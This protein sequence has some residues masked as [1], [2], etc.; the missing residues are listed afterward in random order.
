MK[1]IKYIEGVFKSRWLSKFINQ[2]SFTS[3]KIKIENLIYS[4][5]FLYK[6]NYNFCGLSY[7][8]QALEKIKPIVGLK[9]Y[10]KSWGRKKKIRVASFILPVGLQY[11]KA[12]FWL[13]KSMKLRKEIHLKDKL[14][15]ELNDILCN[16]TSLALKK[17]KEHYKF[18]VMFKAVKKFKW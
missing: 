14:V 8:F 1:Q 5:L 6:R 11:K 10:K 4:V 18:A 12:I 15:N 9:I 2:W 17:K 7:F 13:S 16:T 3:E